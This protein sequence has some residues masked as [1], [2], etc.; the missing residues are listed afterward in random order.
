MELMALLLY[1]SM[2][3][4]L[5]NWVQYLV[6]LSRQSRFEGQWL[7]PGSILSQGMLT[8]YII[9]RGM[10]TGHVPFTTTFEIYVL[11]SWSILAIFLVLNAVYSLQAMGGFVLPVPL[12]FLMIA[13]FQ[14]RGIT[15]PD[16]LGA[17]F[18]AEIAWLHI[19]LIVVAYGAFTVSFLLAAGYLRAEY[20]LRAKSVDHV[21]FLLPSLDVLDRGLQ[22]SIWIGESCLV[23]GFLLGVIEGLLGHEINPSWLIDPNIIGATIT[24]IIYGTILLLRRRSLYTNR[25]IA[26]LTVLGFGFIVLLFGG[27]NYL[28]SMHLFL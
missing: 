4:I 22:L 12:L 5:G 14:P 11:F 27:M 3:L 20:Q 21:F 26:Y 15:T 9:V 17:L 2:V 16:S 19:V 24:V 1:G 28:S 7:L 8:L 18:P 10:K 6:C 25:R 13:H 23:A